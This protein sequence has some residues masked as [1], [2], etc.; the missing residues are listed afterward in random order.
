M[1]TLP[2]GKGGNNDKTNGNRPRS[3]STSS[4]MSWSSI[5]SSGPAQKP[6]SIPSSAKSVSMNS[7]DP[8]EFRRRGEAIQAITWNGWRAN[9]TGDERRMKA[10][11][12][13]SF[14]NMESE[15]AAE[16][17]AL[18]DE[19]GPG[20][21]C[22]ET[23]SIIWVPEPS[24]KETG[25]W[26]IASGVKNT[27]T[28]PNM[29]PKSG[30][31]AALHPRFAKAITLLEAGGPVYHRTNFCCS[32]MHA[33]NMMLKRINPAKNEDFVIPVRESDGLGVNGSTSG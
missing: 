32:E 33:V 17:K 15:F 24:R 10:F 13:D 22:P 26:F 8:G 21:R 3:D 29:R 1:S 18:Q 28:M 19:F 31:T 30:P 23:V 2:G 25:K 7:P 9:E 27:K 16:E 20:A 6:S 14:H 5:V 12:T 4:T 11:L